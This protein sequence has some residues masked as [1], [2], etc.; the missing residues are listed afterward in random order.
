MHFKNIYH[1]FVKMS[2]VYLRKE[3]KKVTKLLEIKGNEKMLNW[4][5]E[6]ENKNKI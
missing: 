5:K 6:K 1:V 2:H 4:E 3:R